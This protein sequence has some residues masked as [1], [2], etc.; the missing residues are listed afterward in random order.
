MDPNHTLLTPDYPPPEHRSANQVSQH[1]GNQQRYNGNRRP[2]H[3]PWYSGNSR[4]GYRGAPGGGHRHQ[5][6][7]FSSNGQAHSPQG[8]FTSNHPGG[9]NLP[10]NYVGNNFNQGYPNNVYP[11]P[12]PGNG[13]S[14]SYPSPNFVPPGGFSGPPVMFNQMPMADVPS[15]MYPSEFT[16][17][18]SPGYPI[19]IGSP[20]F[21]P[22]SPL[23]PIVTQPQA[24]PG[25]IA[26]RRRLPPRPDCPL[27]VSSQPQYDT[28]E[29]MRLYYEPYPANEPFTGV[30]PAWYGPAGGGYMQPCYN[31]PYPPGGGY[32]HSRQS[33]MGSRK[34]I[35]SPPKGDG[36]ESALAQTKVDSEETERGRQLTRTHHANTDGG[37]DMAP[38]A[39]AV[40]KKSNPISM[41]ADIQAELQA[42]DVTG[43]TEIQNHPAAPVNEPQSCEPQ[44]KINESEEAP[45][46]PLTE[47]IHAAASDHENEVPIDKVGHIDFKN[48]ESTGSS[49]EA[50]PK[51]PDTE[52]SRERVGVQTPAPAESVMSTETKT[53]D[54]AETP[55]PAEVVASDN[56]KGKEPAASTPI[57]SG[58]RKLEPAVPDDKHLL[59]RHAFQHREPLKKKYQPKTDTGKT[60]EQYTREINAQRAANDPDSR[61]PEHLLQEVIQELENERR[62]N[63]RKS[64]GLGPNDKSSIGS[65]TSSK[66]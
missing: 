49:S 8:P 48:E 6:P 17:M 20:S 51:T 46:A 58:N 50:G 1:R 40:Q 13:F 44:K 59:A 52:Q 32:P 4:G 36:S 42:T 21:Q 47:P 25:P 60:V 56:G 30:Q 16:P 38:V 35:N 11:Q 39:D 45:T 43:P 9:N 53:P 24:A 37:S 66:N 18:P 31:Q 12:Y 65:D 7:S 57:K 10:Q 19:F 63:A 22:P 33:S 64:R 29:H 2:Y 5:N 3:R 15:P 54:T 27:I 34:N 26:R 28:D 62:E 23:P 61:V 41:R 55:K 14:P